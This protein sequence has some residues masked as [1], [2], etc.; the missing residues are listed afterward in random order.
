MKKSNI[1][2]LISELI[3]LIGGFVGG[4]FAAGLDFYFREGGIR[5]VMFKGARDYRG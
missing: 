5:K 4:P 2:V 1:S 3:D